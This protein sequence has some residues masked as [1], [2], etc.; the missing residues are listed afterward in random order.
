MVKW[1]AGLQVTYI[2]L[3]DESNHYTDRKQ[4]I[5]DKRYEDKNEESSIKN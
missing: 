1:L 4:E 5:N 2:K 3:S